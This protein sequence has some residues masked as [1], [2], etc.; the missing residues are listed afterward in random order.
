MAWKQ[1]LLAW[2]PLQRTQLVQMPML[3]R[4]VRFE[5]QRL[6]SFALRLVMQLQQLPAQ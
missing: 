2:Q 5:P 1:S 4:E 3:E 6:V